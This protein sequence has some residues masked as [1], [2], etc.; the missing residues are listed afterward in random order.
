MD[1]GTYMLQHSFPDENLQPPS[2]T[3]FFGISYIQIF[4]CFFQNTL[5]SRSCWPV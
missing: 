3:V 4:R 2:T 1:S 5:R